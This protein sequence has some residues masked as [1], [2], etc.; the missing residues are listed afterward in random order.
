MENIN[1]IIR[2]LGLLL[3]NIETL[4]GVAVGVAVAA[5]VAYQK[6]KKLWAE[7]DLQAIVAPIAGKAENHAATL[8]HE[9]VNKPAFLDSALTAVSKSDI[10]S[11]VGKNAIVAATAYAEVK[12]EKPSLLKKLG[13]N[14]VSDMIP[15]VSGIYGSI[16]KPIIKGK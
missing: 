12:K 14:S 16:V 13:I 1:E 5:I 4:I 8:L 11:N 6:L 7:R 10:E 3:V 15:I 2:Q 9:L